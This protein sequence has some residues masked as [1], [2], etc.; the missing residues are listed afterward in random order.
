MCFDPHDNFLMNDE[1]NHPGREAIPHCTDPESLTVVL[2]GT[3]SG[4][5]AL[6]NDSLVGH[7]FHSGSVLEFVYIAIDGNAWH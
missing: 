6:A 1:L 7:L 2:A 4:Q 3:L 5:P